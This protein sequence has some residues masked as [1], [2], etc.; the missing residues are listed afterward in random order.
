MVNDILFVN[1]A[2]FG[3]NGSLSQI[4]AAGAT[5]INVGE[6][7]MITL[8]ATSVAVMT[9]NK[10]VVGT[11]YLVGIAVSTSTQTASA[12]GVVKVQPI[13]PGQVWSIAP[14]VAATWD[15]QAEYNALVNH[16]VLIDLTA[17]VYTLLAADSA[18]NGCVV[19]PKDVTS[20]TNEMY[21]TFRAGVSFL[22]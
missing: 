8:G 12:A 11:D 20:D 18:N 1:E 2:E 5:A 9:T 14:K 15:T 4:V 21:F 16:R 13:F 7:V 10:P 22:A 17:G 3:P 6:P 19:M